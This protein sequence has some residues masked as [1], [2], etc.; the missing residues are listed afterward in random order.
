M[1][2]PLRIRSCL[3]FWLRNADWLEKFGQNHND[4]K[5]FKIR[6][7]NKTLVITR[8]FQNCQSVSLARASIINPIH[9]G[10]RQNV[11]CASFVACLAAKIVGVVSTTTELF[12]GLFHHLA[13]DYQKK[14][15][16]KASRVIYIDIVEKLT[17][18]KS[19]LTRGRQLSQLFKNW[20]GLVLAV[21]KLFEDLKEV[22][23]LIKGECQIYPCR[24]Y[25]NLW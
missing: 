16:D 3:E 10:F 22:I 14:T 7:L 6:Q 18:E 25:P 1:T 20:L 21:V 19:N 2:K 11:W 5:V 17:T 9:T 12:F 23:T 24:F 13:L 8:K 15:L 4:V